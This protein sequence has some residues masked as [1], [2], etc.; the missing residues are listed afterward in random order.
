MFAAGAE[1]SD[2]GTMGQQQS[3]KKRKRTKA[4]NGGTIGG[5]LSLEEKL[6]V[7]LDDVHLQE[8]KEL[9]AGNNRTAETLLAHLNLAI[10]ANTETGRDIKV[11]DW[12]M[13]TQIV[14][15]QAI[16]VQDVTWPPSRDDWQKFVLAARPKVSSYDR[17]KK[18]VGNVKSI[19]IRYWSQQRNILSEQ[20]D[21][22]KLYEAVHSTTMR[23]LK[24]EYGMN[25]RQVSPITM[26]EARNATHFADVDSLRGVAA[27][28]AFTLGCLLGGRRPRT[29]TSIRL[30]DIVLT[31]NATVIEGKHVLVPHMSVTFTQEKFDDLSPRHCMDEPH[32][33]N[34]ALIQWW[35]PAYWIYRLLVMR[36]VF[37]TFDPIKFA[38]VGEVLHIRDDCLQ[39]YLFCEVRHSFWC[40]AQPSSVSVISAW[41]QMM[42]E[43][44]GCTKRGFSSHRAGF[45]TRAC[46]LAIMEGHGIELST[47]VLELILQQILSWYCTSLPPSE[48]PQGFLT[49]LVP[50]NVLPK[51]WNLACASAAQ[52]D[53]VSSSRY[54]TRVCETGV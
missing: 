50:R 25:V 17:F 1:D 43:Q 23:A 33:G 35:S 44:M 4:G 51:L 52:R 22:T 11:A 3:C 48:G 9:L 19:G 8:A 46:I 36:G 54:L 18:V 15:N 37:H 31:A 38:S 26:H 6:V 10:T 47:D 49:K 7:A 2:E 30:T 40:D 53:M 34:Y 32:Q 12:L 45:V 28:A 16:S 5:S 21:P 41:N 20:V 27:C 39:F 14:H 13:Y 29:L 24:R 42:L